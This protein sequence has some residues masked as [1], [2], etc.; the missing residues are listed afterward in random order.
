MHVQCLSQTV[1]KWIRDLVK[2]LS[3]LS[4]TLALYEV[5]DMLQI[6]E[7]RTF[8]GNKEH[9]RWVWLALCRRTRQIVAIGKCDEVAAQHLWQLPKP[10]E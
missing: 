8:V 6:N 4:E 5:R 1:I 3:V 7:L 10:K 9:E 2:Q